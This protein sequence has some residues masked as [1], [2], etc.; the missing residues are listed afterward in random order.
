MTKTTTDFRPLPNETLHLAQD[1]PPDHS[2]EAPA[3][4]R[5]TPPAAFNALVREIA[6]R[7]AY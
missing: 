3:L 6:S 5:L 1:A 7:S 2:A 4:V